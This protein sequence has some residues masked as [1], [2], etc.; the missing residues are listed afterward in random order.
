M[1]PCVSCVQVEEDPDDNVALSVL[2]TKADELKAAAKEANRLAKAAAAAA[3]AQG[4]GPTSASSANTKQKPAT[5]SATKGAR[6]A[7]ANANKNVPKPPPKPPP[8]PA[9]PELDLSTLPKLEGLFVCESESTNYEPDSD[10]N[11]GKLK[12]GTKIIH[13]FKAEKAFFLGTITKKR[14]RDWMWEIH[15]EDDN[16]ISK[17]PLKTEDY[18]KTWAIAKLAEESQA[19]PPNW[20]AE[21]GASQHDPDAMPPCS[22]PYNEIEPEAA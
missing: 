8:M 1:L 7:T 14:G 6:T 21:L 19:D 4:L 3:K 18:L 9:S 16:S 20:E 17:S 13:F 15:F 10:F 22:Q 12:I 2:K 5:K 11:T